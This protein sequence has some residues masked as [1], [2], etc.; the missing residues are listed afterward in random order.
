M[1]RNTSNSSNIMDQQEILRSILILKHQQQPNSIFKPT[2]NRAIDDV[3]IVRKPDESRRGSSPS[4]NLTRPPNYSLSSVGSD[5]TAE[6]DFTEIGMDQTSEQY[7]MNT[8]PTVNNQSNDHAQSNEYSSNAGFGPS[9]PPEI[10]NNKDQIDQVS[11]AENQPAKHS[12]EPASPE[13]DDKVTI[14]ELYHYFMYPEITARFDRIEIT[15]CFAD[16]K[17]SDDDIRKWIAKNQGD[18]LTAV[19]A[20]LQA[21]HTSERPLVNDT[22][23]QIESRSRADRTILRSLIRTEQDLQQGSILFKSVPSFQ[24]VV[25]Q[26]RDGNSK[27]RAEKEQVD[28]NF[29]NKVI[30]TFG[31]AGYDA[32]SV[33]KVLQKAE[34]KL[35]R[36]RK[37]RAQLDLMRPTYVRVHSKY[38]S[39]ETLDEYQLP[40]EIDSV[41]LWIH[42]LSV[43]SGKCMW[44]K[45]N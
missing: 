33:D 36:S 34:R 6:S 45:S 14:V 25:Q 23:L 17:I 7:T 32:D 28:A 30:A 37:T 38:M 41:S 15:W 13:N 19:F 16:S 11:S 9:N 44:L 24:L 10:N 3:K 20:T 35:D 40:W 29:R 26:E 2:E 43:E 1:R 39:T 42:D 4:H 12:S 8:K 18:D 27:L 5:Q 21:L 22:L 31:A